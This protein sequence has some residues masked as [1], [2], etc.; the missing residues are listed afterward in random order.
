MAPPLFGP[1]PCPFCGQQDPTPIVLDPDQE[2]SIHYVTCDRCTCTGPWVTGSPGGPGGEDG[3]GG[4][5]GENGKQ[6]AMEAWDKRTETP[7]GWL[8][9]EL[10]GT[11]EDYLEKDQKP[12]PKGMEPCPFCG[13]RELIEMGDGENIYFVHCNTCDAKGPYAGHPDPAIRAWNRRA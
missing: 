3:D 9:P 1:Q 10:R 5:N 4:T 6:K 2:V 13:N 12:I 8:N 11:S 7:E